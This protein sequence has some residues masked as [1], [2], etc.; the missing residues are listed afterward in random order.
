[1]LKS[2]FS[3]DEIDYMWDDFKSRGPKGLLRH[4]DSSYHV[5]YSE[6]SGDIILNVVGLGESHNIRISKSRGFVFHDYDVDVV[7]KNELIDI[8]CD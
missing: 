8:Y 5:D 2:R 6:D 3:F 1:M 7:C 4:A